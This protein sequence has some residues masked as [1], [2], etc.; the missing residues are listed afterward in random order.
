MTRDEAIQSLAE[1]FASWG[2]E[3]VDKVEA[4][5]RAYGTQFGFY[6]ADDGKSG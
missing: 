3:A 2:R 6:V 5:T 1:D 4:G